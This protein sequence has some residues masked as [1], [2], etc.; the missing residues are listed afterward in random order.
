MTDRL[1]DRANTGRLKER[2][3]N[4][5]LPRL[6]VIGNQRSVIGDQCPVISGPSNGP[7]MCFETF[8]RRLQYTYRRLRVWLGRGC[9]EINY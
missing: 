1:F 8:C 6:K 4:E 7:L 2:I 5:P 3:V 9:V